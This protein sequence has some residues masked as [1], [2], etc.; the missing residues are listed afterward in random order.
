MK[1]FDYEGVTLKLGQCDSENDRLIRESR[2][3]HT[4]VHL[5]SFPSGHVVI[6]S[7]D[8]DANVLQVAAQICLQHSKVRSL[9]TAKAIT[10]SV[11]NLKRTDALGEVEFVSRR[12]TRTFPIVCRD[13]SSIAA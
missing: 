12:R 10:T 1:E 3:E 5:N 9:K 13:V 4:W 8:V 7:P 6:Q 11:S 2:P